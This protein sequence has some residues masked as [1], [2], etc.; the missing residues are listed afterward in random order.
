M[1]IPRTL[2]GGL[3][4]VLACAPSFSQ[5]KAIGLE[6]LAADRSAQ[7]ATGVLWR[8]DS[9]GFR[10]E[11]SGKPFYF[12]L[13][14]KTSR[15]LPDCN[16]LCQSAAQPPEPPVFEWINRGVREEK[17]QW[18]RD[19][20][21]MLLKFKGDLF[22]VDTEPDAVEPVRQLTR[23]LYDEADPKLSPD[24]SSVSFRKDYDLYNL[25]VASGAVNA[26][27]R[28]G[29]PDK[30][31]GRL[32]WVYPEELAL[33]SAHW[34]SP[35]SERIAFLRFDI[36]LEPAYPQVDY[37]SNPPRAEPERYP[38]AGETNAAVRLAITNRSGAEPRFVEL[39]DPWQ[40]LIARVRWL[41]DGKRLAVERLNRIQNEL[42][43]FFVNSE[44]L[45]TEQILTEKDEYW[46]NLSDDFTYLPALDAFLWTS[47]N[48]GH[49]HL[50]LY[51]L[52]D[53][54]A[55]QLTKGDWDVTEVL[56][57]DAEQRTVYY[58]AT[59]TSPLGRQ[60]FAMPIEGGEV[61]ELSNA[62]GTW[63][64]RFSPD[65][66]WWLGRHSRTDLPPDQAVYT[67]NGTTHATL[68]ERDKQVLS[69]YDVLPTEFH[70]V[71]LD[72]GT[73]LYGRLIRPSN[74]KTG[75][76]YPVIVQ[77]YGGPHAQNVRDTWSGLTM[78][79]VYAHRGFVVW[80]LDNRG[81]SGRG[82]AFE[83]PVAR[84]LGVIELSDQL[85]G[86]E[87]LKKLG[88]VD[89]KRIGVSGWS[90]GGYMTLNCLLNAPKTFKAGIAG[91][92]VVDWRFYD[93]IYTE[94][95]MDL[96]EANPSGY[97][98]SSLLDK[99][100]NLEA[101]LLLIHNLSDDNV[102]FQN[103]VRIMDRLQQAG[104]PFELMIYPQKT[105]GVT[106]NAQRHMQ[107]MM[108]DFFERTLKTS[109]AS[110]ASPH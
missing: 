77:V 49:R 79:Q 97:A 42:T 92:P 78:D 65:G 82:H 7:V 105:H 34:W 99:A 106:G 24:C 48:T 60:V 12:D 1:R 15:E 81:T 104:K 35:D 14:S 51:Y 44:T 54:Y 96:P 91:A 66:A 64:A 17:A 87:Y 27:T 69:R 11:L 18:C 10:Y 94:R 45:E 20:R 72:D 101:S 47:E 16:L 63:E 83:I 59:T 80:Q 56:G 70:T 3:L 46:I 23:T 73:T 90:Y 57:V 68:H 62:P 41:P 25:N 109:R 85:K 28:G 76:R 13:E 30:M 86:I 8:P 55:R 39:G 21:H 61:R 29:S 89:E 84:R 50:Y 37:L 22:W 67:A 110:H 100:G 43:L 108:L 52:K 36:T 74:F 53:R 26:I 102:H 2:A 38:K 40:Y 31:N 75:R 88:F 6:D 58:L 19:N 95:Y 98:R 107:R 103:S 33:P 5:K 32:D 71:K 4:A 93:T 9:K